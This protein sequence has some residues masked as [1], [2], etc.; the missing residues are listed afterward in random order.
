MSNNNF[1]NSNK[2]ISYKPIFAN[3][4]LTK[5]VGIVF[6]IFACIPWVNFGL[7]RMDSQPWSF[8][9]A[10][11]FLLLISQKITIPKNGTLMLLLVIIGL[12][13]TISLTNSIIAFDVGRALVQYLT[14]PIMYIAF[15]NFFI[16]YEFPL[17][18]FIFMNL[19][20]IFFGFMEIFFFDF[21]NAISHTR[22]DYELRG[23]TSLASEP[24]FFGIY[25][26]FSSWIL[27]ESNNFTM[28]KKIKMLLLAN[29][30]VVAFFAK[31]SMVILFYIIVFSLILLRKIISFLLGVKI[32]INN[33]ITYI[34]YFLLIFISFNFFQQI[35]QGSRVEQLITKI[36]IDNSILEIIVS[37]HSINSRTEAVFFSVIGT[38]DNYLIPGG[39]DSFIDVRR[40]MLEEYKV[41]EFFF[42][43]SESNKIMSWLGSILY[44]LGIFGLFLVIII[45]KSIYKSF[46]G[47][48][49]YYG[50]FLVILLSAVPVAFPLVPMLFA[51]IVYNKKKQ[52]LDNI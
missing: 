43:R 25:L 34:F 7:N 19:V 29:F 32:S 16:R 38:F 2:L 9:L 12:V 41:S 28:D 39:L 36:N 5:F 37:D 49:F 20:W 42:N 44:E 6:I 18:L 47:S 45:F 3:L 30:L 22:T 40:S 31:A 52:E 24:T 50:A 23:V 14:I 1:V 48:L 35:L 11:S 8:L 15:Y 33:I 21:V 51:L 13:V 4:S 26:F 17:K 10:L 27:I 46:G